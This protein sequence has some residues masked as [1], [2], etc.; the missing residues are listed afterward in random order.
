V[1]TF[2]YQLSNVRNII[3]MMVCGT[4]IAGIIYL[5]SRL[6]RGT[7]QVPW[8]WFARVALIAAAAAVVWLP[9]RYPPQDFLSPALP[10]LFLRPF[11]V[12]VYAL[13]LGALFSALAL[14][15]RVRAVRAAPEDAASESAARDPE[16]D[17]AL[18]EI[19]FRLGQAQIDLGRQHVYVLLAPH[20]DWSEALVRS[21]GL[22][23][24]ARAPEGPAPIH[25]YATAE[26]VLLSV[27]GASAF[28]TQDAEGSARLEDLCRQLLGR[29]PERPPLHGIAVLFPI[30]WAARPE[31]VKWAAAVRD[32]VR[33]VQRA[34]K[35]RCPVFALHVEMETVPGFLAFID[36]MPRDFRGSRVGFSVPVS[37]PFSGDLIN[38]G[39]TWM[40]GWFQSWILN[41]MS[42]NPLEQAANNELASLANEVR[43]FRKRLRAVMEAAFS[44]PLGAEPVAFHGCYF[45]ATGSG[46]GEQ[47]FAAGLLVGARSRLIAA[48]LATEWTAEARDDDWR[49]KQ[50]AIGVGIGGVLLTLLSW[51]YIINVTQNPLWWIGVVVL[52]LAW[53]VAAVR[54][55]SW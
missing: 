4:I 32:D 7:I 16:V 24:F 25:A 15:R 50:V 18:K 8:R 54:L 48:H 36:R 29:D 17:A 22:Q 19:Q 40:A 27:T 37:T 53:V 47:A 44:T 33:A 31:S 49:Y 46:P 52:C 43:R 14:V 2:L 39:L 35:V 3:T 20:E 23:V 41:R 28:G 38:R 12:W 6:I 26:G 11:W 42:E 55:S 1:S 21:A 5:V 34:M 45:A 30:S 13:T 10:E 51:L 9:R